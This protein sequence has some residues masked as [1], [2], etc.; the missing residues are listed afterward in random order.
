MHCLTGTYVQENAPETDP[1]TKELLYPVRIV[2]PPNKSR[3]LYFATEFLQ[4]KWADAI[5]HI[6]G[7]SNVHDFYKIEENLGKGQF[8]VVKLSTHKRN[9]NQV[10]IKVI[11]KANMKPIEVYQQRREIEVLKMCQH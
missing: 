7:F 4:K 9:G 8:G 5:R 1:S 11:T 6:I 2:I 3:I 10:A